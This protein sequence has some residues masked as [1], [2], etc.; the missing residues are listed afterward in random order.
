[1]RN[2]GYASR[3]RLVSEVNRRSEGIYRIELGALR[4]DPRI[5]VREAAAPTDSQIQDILDRLHRLDSRAS[6]GAWT[7]RTLDVIRRNPGLRAADLCRLMGQDKRPFK[8]NVRKLKNLG[9]TETLAIRL[10][11][12]AARRRGAAR[13]LCPA[14]ADD[15]ASV[16]SG[17]AGRLP[18]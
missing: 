6:G 17:L 11:P 8:V 18:W 7:L 9:L 10:P 3:E 5:A 4:P 15:C 13:P 16:G 14:L 12:V 1:M 2:A